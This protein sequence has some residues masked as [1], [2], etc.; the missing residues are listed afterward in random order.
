MRNIKGTNL[1]LDPN[2]SVEFECNQTILKSDEVIRDVK[3]C[4]NFSHPVLERTILVSYARGMHLN[5][6]CLPNALFTPLLEGVNGVN[7]LSHGN[8]DFKTVDLIG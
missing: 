1:L 8:G 7:C 3:R 2:L 4:P 5:D 6:N